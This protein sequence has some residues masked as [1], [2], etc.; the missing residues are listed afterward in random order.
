MYDN[1]NLGFGIEYLTNTEIKDTPSEISLI[2]LYA[3]YRLMQNAGMQIFG[4]IGYSIPELSYNDDYGYYGS[5]PDVEGG[6]MY[7]FHAI[8]NNK[9]Q[10]SYTIHEAQL[11]SDNYDYY[12]YYYYYYDSDNDPGSFTINRM[13]IFY[14][15]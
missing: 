10:F 14:L 1:N 15:F 3:T 9:L 6:L 5:S 7:G 4:K 11:D 12:Y 8:L 2:N 13:S